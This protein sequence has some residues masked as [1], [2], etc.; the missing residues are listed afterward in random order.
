MICNIKNVNINF[1]IGNMEIWSAFSFFYLIIK[2]M[3]HLS[4]ETSW[5]TRLGSRERGETRFFY[6]LKQILN[7]EM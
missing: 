4:C 7:R 3:R 2:L 5:D 1:K 6:F